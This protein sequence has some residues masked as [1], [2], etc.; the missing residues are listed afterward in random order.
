MNANFFLRSL[1]EHRQEIEVL[2]EIRSLDV[3]CSLPRCALSIL[4][5]I[6]ASGT[7]SHPWSL[8][9]ILLQKRLI[10]VVHAYEALDQHGV[11]PMSLFTNK[12]IAQKPVN[13][14]TD[15]KEQLT[16]D[17]HDMDMSEFLVRNT[18]GNLKFCTLGNPSSQPSDGSH[19]P[20]KQTYGYFQEKALAAHRFLLQYKEG[21]Y[22]KPD[23]HF[24][25]FDEATA[26]PT[27]YA[28]EFR[29]ALSP[30]V[31]KKLVYMLKLLQSFRLSPPWTLQRICALLCAPRRYTD[32]IW[33]IITAITGLLWT[34]AT[35]P[36]HPYTERKLPS[37]LPL[38]YARVY[39]EPSSVY[40][41]D[42]HLNP[43][44]IPDPGLST[45]GVHDSLF[46]NHFAADCDVQHSPESV[47]DNC[48]DDA[49][50]EHSSSL[51]TLL[52]M[53]RKRSRP[54]DSLTASSA[55][56]E[57][58]DEDEDKLLMESLASSTSADNHQSPSRR[59]F[60]FSSTLANLSQ[61]YDYDDAD[62]EEQHTDS[63]IV[64]S[65]ESYTGTGSQ[66][67]TTKPPSSSPS[68][69]TGLS[70]HAADLISQLLNQTKGPYSYALPG[71]SRESHS[72]GKKKNTSLGSKMSLRQIAGV[73][74]RDPPASLAFNGSGD[75]KDDVDDIDSDI[76]SKIAEKSETLYFE[77]E[78]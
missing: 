66:S 2:K 57:L 65:E 10:E 18:S 58:Q 75:D 51:D 53:S 19:E 26:I 50:N 72:E 43:P 44:S 23:Y 56:S 61:I 21:D 74:L 4:Q 12:Y 27:F 35:S 60:G 42:H 34:S 78:K 62:E 9:N 48:Q 63:S 77:A 25:G 28:V 40:K 13:D 46:S 54:S 5:D 17:G 8:L 39:K 3:N 30:P 16:T 69:G 76:V 24:V 20:A 36:M 55:M 1:E 45:Q 67:G 29:Y 14:S 11:T 33:E 32:R 15:A 70:K 41:R 49:E 47:V 6:V 52:E 73:N 38:I 68:L 71:L 37:A 7:Y 31:Q 22:V 59:Q 64:R